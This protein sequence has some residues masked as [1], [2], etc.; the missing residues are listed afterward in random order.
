VNK[1]A[2][3]LTLSLCTTC[4]QAQSNQ[5]N[6]NDKYIKTNECSVVMLIIS[7]II[8]SKQPEN[9]K[10]LELISA[11]FMDAADVYKKAGNIPEANAKQVRDINNNKY[12]SLIGKDGLMTESGHIRLGAQQKEC[13][14]LQ[15]NDPM[16]TAVV[17]RRITIGK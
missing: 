9:S 14:E 7:S 13:N 4:A 1:F 16:I 6:Y 11:G 8:H 10:T 17:N 5:T 2:Y 3:A 15:K 12:F